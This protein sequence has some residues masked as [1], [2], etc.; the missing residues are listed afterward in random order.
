MRTFSSILPF[1][2]RLEQRRATSMSTGAESNRGGRKK[3][4]V[5][6]GRK[7]KKTAQVQPQNLTKV[8]ILAALDVFNVA[9]GQVIESEKLK[10]LAWEQIQNCPSGN[11]PTE[12][13][14]RYVI[15]VHVLREGER[16][17]FGIEWVSR[18][19][20]RMPRRG[21][22][23]SMG[24]KTKSLGETIFYQPFADYLVQLRECTKAEKMG[25]A[26]R[27]LTWGN[28]DIF[29]VFTP[30]FAVNRHNFPTEFVAAEVKSAWDQESLIKGFGQACVYK[31]FAHKSYLVVPDEQFSSPEHI[32]RL[33]ALC[34]LFGVGLCLFNPTQRKPKFHIRV[35]A[36]SQQPDSIHADEFIEALDPKI[37]GILGI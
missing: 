6:Q 17:K 29:G 14:L 30:P 8:A 2:H 19:Q 11:R 36:R 34:G 20:Y 35:R 16:E 31:A 4:N 13:Y 1:T 37:R 33:D 23:K 26:P 27:M 12:N 9:G 15:S 10:Q 28:P 21:I 24:K 22:K 18:G 7:T 32:A 25:G 5:R 3:K